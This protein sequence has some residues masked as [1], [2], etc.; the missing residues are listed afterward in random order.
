MAE[1]VFNKDGTMTADGKVVRPKKLK[2]TTGSNGLT[3]YV[4]TL[5]ENGAVSCTCP[6]W[7]IKKAGKNR[8]CK[9]TKASVA[10]QFA[11]MQTPSQIVKAQLR[12]GA[13][14]KLSEHSEETDDR[15]VGL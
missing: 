5:W 1:P 3:Q 4:T 2:H 12:A 15:I 9:H 10:A 13:E 8:E 11:D 6:G 7:T 14:V